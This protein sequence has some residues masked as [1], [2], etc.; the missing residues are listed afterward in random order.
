MGR[1]STARMMAEFILGRIEIAA[2]PGRLRAAEA[3]SALRFC[4]RSPA[5]VGP[6]DRAKMES[7]AIG[8]GRVFDDQ[9]MHDVLSIQD[10]IGGECN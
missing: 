9:V 4:P 1:Q 10:L 7:E 8:E 6:G 2:A 5:T 3:G